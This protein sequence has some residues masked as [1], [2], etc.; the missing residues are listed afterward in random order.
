VGPRLITEYG[1]FQLFPSHCKHCGAKPV[2]CEN[3]RTE[4]SKANEK[5]TDVNIAT[6]MM[7]D[8]IEKKTDCVILISGD[9]DY[10]T[11]LLEMGRLFPNVMRVIAVPP[12]RR[13]PRMYSSCDHYFDIER[14]PIVNSQLPNPVVN[15]NNKKKYTMP[16]EWA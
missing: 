1:R 12:K 7:V 9:S 5:K 13:N 15:P 4:Y 2:Y 8:C 6:M 10:E 11:T 14:D 3:C 16:P